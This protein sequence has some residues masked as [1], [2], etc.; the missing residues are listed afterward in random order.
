VSD[1]AIGAT[2]H[3]HRTTKSQSSADVSKAEAET[4]AEAVGVD[5]DI[6][7]SDWDR[8][9]NATRPRERVLIER[10]RHINQL[11]IRGDNV[12]TISEHEP[13]IATAAAAAIPNP[14]PAPKLSSAVS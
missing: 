6:N 14:E 10:R 12:V 2:D 11:F 1:D 8:G 13:N 3:K 9:S 5:S 4:E 7:Y